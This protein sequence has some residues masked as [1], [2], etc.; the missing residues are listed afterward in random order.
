MAVICYN[1][2][3][4]LKKR[5]PR[6][7]F[8]IRARWSRLFRPIAIMR[9]KR[10][11]KF[12]SQ[13]IGPGDLCF[14][15]G[16][17]RGTRTEIFLKLGAKVVAVEP[18]PLCQEIIQRCGSSKNLVIINKGLAAE[19]GYANLTITERS[20]S[21]STMS[22]AWKT[23]GRF[24]EDYKFSNVRSI[25]VPVITLDFLI[26]KYGLPKFCKIDVEGFEKEVIMGLTK[27]IPFISFEFMKEFLDN[28]RICMDH[29]L[30]LGDA[31]FNFTVAD[32]PKLLKDWVSADELFLMLKS[33]QNKDLWGDI[34]V[35]FLKNEK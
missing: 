4:Y 3:Y 26:N 19:P 12:Y 20:D 14:D 18:H 6:F 28:T 8:F 1:L 30:T 31:K 17:H 10:L 2:K 25:S 22:E 16:A 5:F 24:A 7:Y 11:P 29:L 32:T 13:F 9:R 21:I 34:Y 23:E 35:R 27:P 33:N 15:I